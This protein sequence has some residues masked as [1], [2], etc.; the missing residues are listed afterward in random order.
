[1][2]V[3]KV[4]LLRKLE[5][6]EDAFRAIPRDA[7]A[8]DAVLIIGEPKI[9]DAHYPPLPGARAE[10]EAVQQIFD[11]HA[12]SAG[13]STLLLQSRFDVII[14]TLMRQPWRIVHVAGHGEPVR[15]DRDGLQSGG[16]VLSDK[17]Y[18][19]PCEIAALDVV[20]ELVF[21]NC[22][23]LGGHE[24]TDTLVLPED[25]A[26]FAA[27]V[28]DALIGLGVRCVI[29]AGWAVD[30]DPA[31]V[32][33]RAFYG[34]LLNGRPFVDA[35]TEARRAARVRNPASKTWAA[36]QCY[37]D[38]SWTFR[39]QNSDAQAPSQREQDLHAFPSAV[40]LALALENLAVDTNVGTTPRDEARAEAEAMAQVHQERWGGI[41]AVAEAFGVVWDAVG[42]RTRAI[43]CY[44]AA[45]QA[46]DASASMK[47]V[48]SLVNV[49]VR[50]A[51]ELA[52]SKQ[53][54]VD[55]ARKTINEALA[56]LDSLLQLQRTVER[57]A[58]RG[59]ALK[60]LAQLQATPDD[61]SSAIE[62]LLQ[63]RDAYQEAED[64]AARDKAP[65]LYYPAINRIGIELALAFRDPPAA[66]CC[67]SRWRKFRCPMPRRLPAR[68]RTC[69][70]S[71]AT[72]PTSGSTPPPPSWS[73]R[74]RWQ[75]ASWRRSSRHWP[76]A[77]PTC[78]AA[79]RTRRSGSRCTSRRASC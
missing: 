67:G 9:D 44:A 56:Q 24:A 49:R 8:E 57:L 41:G 73:S 43:A 45:V 13:G 47:A 15:Q 35:V 63:A 62:P 50:Q 48:E 65:D 72:S 19:G 53:I 12:R 23:H 59:S 18:L 46:V 76:R 70:S 71:S 5:L 61:P 14:N 38:P 10:A 37:G 79:C 11:T 3:S 36:Y 39:Q 30:D 32:F 74:R 4:G 29:A 69:S 17:V 2:R 6:R 34:A 31:E 40:G 66:G 75:S 27:G 16:V 60:R 54:T 21:V 78:M 33:A 26:G 77:G 64:L 42:D 20:P 28:A 1:M 58:L 22:C 25:T 51:H 68:R 52:L 55:E 7:R